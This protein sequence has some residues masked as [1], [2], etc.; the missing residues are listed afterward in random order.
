MFKA[1]FVYRA[2]LRANLQF[3]SYITMQIWLWRIKSS[4]KLNIK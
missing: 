4:V 3:R 1:Y 2:K